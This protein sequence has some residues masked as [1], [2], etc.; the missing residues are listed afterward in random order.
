[1]GGRDVQDF[2]DSKKYK[3][4]D[5]LK[6]KDDEDWKVMK[7]KDN[8][9]KLVIKPHNEKAKKGNISLEIDVDLDYLK[10]N[11]NEAKSNPEVDK[12]LNKQDDR[13]PSGG[14]LLQE[15]VSL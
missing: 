13:F 3:V 6:F 10:N 4:G 8:V 1:M 15:E 5:I 7:V 11:L 14:E 2:I 12:L 9:G